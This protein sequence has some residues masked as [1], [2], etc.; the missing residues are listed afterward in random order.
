MYDSED[1]RNSL[2]KRDVLSRNIWTPIIN[3]PPGTNISEIA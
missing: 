3:V 2:A 1:Y